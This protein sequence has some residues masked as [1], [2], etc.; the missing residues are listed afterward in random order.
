MIV[1]V[2]PWSV[3]KGCR[4]PKV[5]NCIKSTPGAVSEAIDHATADTLLPLVALITAFFVGWRLREE[6]LK[7][8]LDRRGDFVH[9]LPTRPRGPDELFCDFP[10]L[11]R[12]IVCDAQHDAILGPFLKDGNRQTKRASPRVE[13]PFEM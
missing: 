9:I 3:D 6:V 10:V 4:N 5:L 12:D 2:V 13:K 7:P 11:N 1:R 8:Q